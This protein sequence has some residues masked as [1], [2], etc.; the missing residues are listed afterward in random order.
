MLGIDSLSVRLSELLA[1]TCYIAATMPKHEVADRVLV[2]L[3]A[4]RIR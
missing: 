1:M 2:K 3:S 4:G